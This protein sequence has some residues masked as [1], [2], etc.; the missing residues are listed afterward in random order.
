VP[1]AGDDEGLALQGPAPTVDNVQT[2]PV[3]A[4]PPLVPRT[5]RNQNHV[6]PVQGPIVAVPRVRRRQVTAM[7]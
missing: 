2:G 1:L 7:P 4:L 6:S 3:R 5:W